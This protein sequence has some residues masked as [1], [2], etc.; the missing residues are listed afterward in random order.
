[1]RGLFAELMQFGERVSEAALEELHKRKNRQLSEVR[2]ILDEYQTPP[3]LRLDPSRTEAVG[4]LD[5]TIGHAP[6][7][8]VIA[9]PTDKEGR[10]E[11]ISKKKK[12]GAGDEFLNA[13]AGAALER[14]K[15]MNG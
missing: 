8:K 15:A 13:K 14:L 4:K 7:Q 1:M 3:E 2:A 11:I 5:L 12:S 10:S 6:R 9:L